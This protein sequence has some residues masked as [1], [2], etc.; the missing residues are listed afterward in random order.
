KLKKLLPQFLKPYPALKK[1]RLKWPGPVPELKFPAPPAQKGT[2]G[3]RC[4]IM[5]GGAAAKKLLREFV[6]KRL[7]AYAENRNDP[8]L[9]GQSGLSPYFHF[10]QLSAQS[11][12]LSVQKSKAPGNAK[13]AFLE[14]LLV[15]RELSD[16]FCFYTPDYDSASS[17][18]AWAQASL[19]KEAKTRRAYLYS[20]AQLEN[21]QTHDELWNA[22]QME[23]VLTG[24]MHGYMRMYWGKKILEWSPDFQ[25]AYRVAVALNDKYEL[26][27][28]DP[29]GY[30]GAAWAI[31]G[32]HDRPWPS[33]PIF[34]NVRFMSR[35]GCESKFDAKAYIAASTGLL[36]KA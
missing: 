11:A 3:S 15:R 6:E 27:G 19:L 10:G 35:N 16:N 12:A 2:A 32:V 13:A 18:P 34:G 14:E 1:Q 4:E 5:P 21:A 7:G 33:R 29:N 30:A 17:F 36:K 25:Q 31:G 9:D 23:M 22:A 24:K 28:R 20:P 8:S 26:D